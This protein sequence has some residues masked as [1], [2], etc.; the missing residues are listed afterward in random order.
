MRKERIVEKGYDSIAEIYDAD[1][2]KIKNQQ[3][4]SAFIGLLEKG[5]RILDLGCGAGVPISK[6]LA[7][8]GFRVT[9]IDFS[10]R[11]LGIAKKS[12]PGAEFIRKDMTKLDFPEDSFDG[13]VAFYSIIHVP[14]Q[15]HG[16]IFLRLH[17]VLRSGGVILV[18]MGADGWEAVQ[19]YKGTKMFW[20]QFGPEKNI[21]LIKEAGFEIISGEVKTISGETH[22]WVLARN[23]KPDRKKG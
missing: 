5:S 4:L 10:E 6:E 3:E 21:S 15:K 17:R 2:S 19:G 8:K 14:R 18:C 20:S 12:V 23:V 1:R 7:A 13:A 11:M 22:M 16:A 9:G